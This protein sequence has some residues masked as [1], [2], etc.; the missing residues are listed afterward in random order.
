M[1]GTRFQYAELFIKH[2][3]CVTQKARKVERGIPPSSAQ[4]KQHQNVYQQRQYKQ[5]QQGKQSK[6]QLTKNS[7]AHTESGC[8]PAYFL[9]RSLITGTRI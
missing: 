3:E 6:Q 5:Q 7:Q 2:A 9:R 4:H 1:C 8:K